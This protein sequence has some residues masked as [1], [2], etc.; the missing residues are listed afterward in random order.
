MFVLLPVGAVAQEIPDI[1][2]LLEENELSTAREDYEEITSMLLH[3]AA[4]P[5]PLNRATFEEL[6]QLVF[7][8]DSQIDNIIR[9]RERTGE[10]RHASELL[11]VTGIGRRELE[12][13]LPFIEITPPAPGEWPVT[14]RRVTREIL[15]RARATRPLQA[16]YKRYDRDAFLEE[17]EYQ[18]H[19]ENRF[20]GPAW[21]TLLKY[22]VDGGSF[23]AGITLENDAGEG[24]FSRHQG[25]GFDFLSAHAAARV[26]RVVERVIVG[27]Y[28]LQLG[29]GLVAWNG[30]ARGKS[31][32]ALGNEKAARGV[33]PYTS[34]DE[35][36]FARGIAVVTRPLDGLTTTL[37]W[38]SKRMDARVVERDTLEPE[39]AWGA[40]IDESGYH[41]DLPEIRRKHALKEMAG[42]VSVN[43]NH[44]LFRVGTHAL[45]YNFSPQLKVGEREYQR[46][47]D[48]GRRRFLAGIDYKSGFAGFYFFGETAVSDNRSLATVNGIRYSGFSSL[49]LAVIYRRY[50][51]RYTSY[52]SNGFGEY[53]NTSNEE[54]VYVGVEATPARDLKVNFYH[55]WFRYFSPR[56][57]ATAPG[58]GREMTCEI[59]YLR[60]CGEWSARLKLENKPE[61]VRV[62][63]VT[64]T[65]PRARREYRLQYAWRGSLPL[66]ESRTRF[67]YIRHVKG[68]LPESGFLVYH[69]L[70]LTFE[71]P[72]LKT[73][74]RLA[75]FDIE[76]YNARVYVYE[77]NVLHGYSFPA[78]YYRG[79]R[80]YI[81]VNWKPF[82]SVTFYA[83][84]GVVYY[85]DRTSI[86]SSLSRVDDNKLFDLALQVR[87]KL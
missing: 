77:N 54:G 14:R 49:A 39:N 29:Q 61:D 19:V 86:G 73:Q 56:Y 67:D 36:C 10:F 75:Y 85:P 70:I 83:K 32:A 3:L 4:H 53:S 16:G 45:Y 84:G 28:R 62:D 78:Y 64:R 22:K 18:K 79:Y 71:K 12:S 47:N 51:K 23:Q 48:S 31:L 20:Q 43:Y 34:A 66:V 74:F 57:R 13:I 42:G 81:N 44:A 21:G 15:A 69:D 82:R 65:I 59:V 25:T 1:E 80:S 58:S 27:D 2:R 50:D 17:S 46:Y 9:F 6:K 24:Y 38:S 33:I 52:Y 63:Q 68:S 5:L 7:L 72:R 37:F 30:F 35:N 60:P 8:S 40:T 55:D 41:R 26:S 76:S 87:V 11:L